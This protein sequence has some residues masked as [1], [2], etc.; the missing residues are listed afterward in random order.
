MAISVDRTREI[1]EQYA[2]THSADHVAEDA[3]YTAMETGQEWKGRE[4]VAESLDYMYSHA[5]DAH[6]EITN[7]FVGEGKA[8]LE[9]WFVGTHKGEFAGIPPTGK[10]VRV[11]LCVVYDIEDDGIK[12]ARIYMPGLVQQLLD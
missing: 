8:L 2:H 1:L 12:R 11:P 10:E 4:A 6:A 5:F 3:V 7:S 9:A